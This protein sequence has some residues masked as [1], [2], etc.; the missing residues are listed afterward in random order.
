MIACLLPARNCEQDIP[1]YLDCAAAFADTVIALDD[2][3][4]D[5]TA[6][7][8]AASPL[9]EALLQNPRRETYAGWEDSQNR[10]RLLD[11]A[12]EAGADWVLFLDADERIDPDDAAALRRFLEGAADPGCAYGFR[13][14]RMVGDEARYDRSE[15]WV[16]RLFSPA[17]G[18]RLPQQQLHLV[19]VP[20]SIPRRDWHKTTI[21]IKHLASLT[22][23]RRRARLRKYEQ[24]D[25]ER[26]WQRDYANLVAEPAV[27][28]PWRPRPADFPVL[29][30][31]GVSDGSEL[32]LETLDPDAPLLS[33]IVISRNDE[34]TIERSLQALVEQDCPAP[35]EVI[36]AVSGSDRTEEI[37]RSRFPAVTVTRVPEPGLPGAARNAGLALAR[38]EYVS[39]PGSHVELPQGSL[40]A[41]LR[42]HEDGWAMVTGSI[43]NGTLTPAGW[44]SYFLDH[45]SALPGRPSGRLRGAPAHCSY[46]REFLLEVGGFPEGMRAG[47]DTVVNNELWRAGYRAYRAQDLVLVHRSPCST[48]G[49]LVRHHFTRGR[50]LGQILSAGPGRHGRR[51]SLA[52]FLAGYAGR[53]LLDTDR[54]VATWGEEFGDEYGSARRWVKL[55][56]AAAWAGAWFELVA[57]SLGTRPSR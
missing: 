40:A 50:A 42:A 9:V 51:R 33:A 12:R 49:R 18:G 2:G 20:D 45:S 1:G 41:R 46:V 44:A 52:R 47:E 37:V 15:L 6:E 11:A 16:Y 38:G 10:Q 43:R 14:F 31:A 30:G 39:F 22:E 34:N 27:A 3:S 8:L 7:L 17:A 57:P 19:P 29:A 56:I 28:R 54:R 26:R 25:P 36:V 48:V 24:A 5:A 4:T 21:R 53:R 35:F 55:G 32:D 13:V 23:D